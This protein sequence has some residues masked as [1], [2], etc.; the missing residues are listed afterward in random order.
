[1]ASAAMAASPVAAPVAAPLS[2][3]LLPRLLLQMMLHAPVADALEAASPVAAASVADTPVAW[4]LPPHTAK[5]L[6][7]KLKKK[8]SKKGN[9]AVS[10]SISTFIYR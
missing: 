2:L 10:V 3:L 9:G 7:R 1:M 6:Y 8:Y 5:I 4:L